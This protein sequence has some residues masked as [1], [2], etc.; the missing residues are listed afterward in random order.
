MD[1]PDQPALLIMDKLRGQTTALV[2]EN[3][4][5]NNILVAAV[6]AGTTDKLQPLDF[7]VS[8]KATK[9]FCQE[10]FHHWYI[11]QVMKQLQDHENPKNTHVNLS[12]AVMKKISA[13]W[14][15]ALYAN[16]RGRPELITNAF[17]EA[18]IVAVLEDQ[19]QSDAL[20]DKD[21]FADLD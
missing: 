14:L 13:Q 16:F 10:R 19:D 8:I 4:E 20:S 21:P 1:S 15:T 11:Q 12:T 17:R 6:P 18:W 9:D 2:Q 7:I 5:D 3:L